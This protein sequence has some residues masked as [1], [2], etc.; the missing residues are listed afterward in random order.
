M[1]HQESF[2]KLI[3]CLTSIEIVFL[4]IIKKLLNLHQNAYNNI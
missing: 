2:L 4:S 1:K 3:I